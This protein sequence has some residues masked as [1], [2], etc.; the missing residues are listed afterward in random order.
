MEIKDITIFF[1][2]NEAQKNKVEQKKSQ[3]LVNHTV[4]LFNY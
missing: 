1:I 2:L 3:M 4:L